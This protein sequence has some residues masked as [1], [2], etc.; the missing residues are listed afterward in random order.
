MAQAFTLLFV[1]DDHQVRE[2]IVELLRARGFHVLSAGSGVEAMRIL[3]QEPV[4]V[5][6]TDIVM[7]D[8]DGLE[9]A[10]RS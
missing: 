2:P 3:A 10:R 9:L 8:Q 5:L 6:F 7:P 4:D 1:D